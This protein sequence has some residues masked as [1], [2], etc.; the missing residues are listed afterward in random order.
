MNKRCVIWII[1]MFALI[2]F[3]VI[4][5]Q[6]FFQKMDNTRNLKYQINTLNL[7]KMDDE[8]KLSNYDI[9]KLMY[10]DTANIR[11]SDKMNKEQFDELIIILKDELKKIDNDLYEVF[12]NFVSYDFESSEIITDKIYLYNSK[13]QS[14]IINEIF[15]NDYVN[16]KRIDT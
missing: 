6:I 11:A 9:I 13:M 4:M 10:K 3:V 8:D 2:G 5:P 14:A 12:N 15:I 7:K 16:D 1:I